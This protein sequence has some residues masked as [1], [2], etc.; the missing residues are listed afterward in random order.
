MTRGIDHDRRSLDRDNPIASV[1]EGRA[2]RSEHTQ[3]TDAVARGRRPLSVL[4]L[5]START[6]NPALR[7]WCSKVY[8]PLLVIKNGSRPEFLGNAPLRVALLL[9]LITK[10]GPDPGATLSL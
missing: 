3:T 10:R 8:H 2:R 5:I 1:R 9:A 6:P 4:M 7:K